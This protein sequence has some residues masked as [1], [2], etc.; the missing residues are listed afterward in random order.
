MLSSTE[1]RVS[2]PPSRPAPRA[3]GSTAGSGMTSAAQSALMFS[4]L[5]AC[6]AGRSGCQLVVTHA[7]IWRLRL[8]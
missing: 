1:M 6:P 8:R 7:A 5:D 3:H 2:A 4:A